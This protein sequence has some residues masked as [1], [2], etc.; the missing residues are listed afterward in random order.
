M[1]LNGCHMLGIVAVAMTIART[2]CAMLTT[3]LL[4][5]ADLCGNNSLLVARY[6][7]AHAAVGPTASVTAIIPM[8][9][10]L[11][12]L[13]GLG[14]CMFSHAYRIDRLCCEMLLQRREGCLGC[15]HII[16]SISGEWLET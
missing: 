6:P 11:L 3:L 2:A 16:S 4:N 14:C 13:P 9:V 15:C 7:I 12:Q 5:S 8:H 1:R 10:L